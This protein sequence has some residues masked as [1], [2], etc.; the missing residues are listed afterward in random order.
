MNNHCWGMSIH[1][2]ELLYG[3]VTKARPAASLSASMDFA[4]VA[5]GAGC[6]SEKV[7]DVSG[8]KDA[9]ARLVEQLDAGKPAL[10]ELA[11]DDQPVHPGTIAM[12]GNSDNKNE[13]V[14]PYY[15]NVPRPRF[16]DD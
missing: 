13:V 8:I 6:T 11:V 2:Q 3:H 14:I 4:A 1:G 9:V 10:L 12:V 7:G 16:G 15:D 5:K